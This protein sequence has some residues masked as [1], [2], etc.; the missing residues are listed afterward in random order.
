MTCL[1]RRTT[2]SETV[3]GGVSSSSSAAIAHRFRAKRMKLDRVTSCPRPSSQCVHSRDRPAG[4]GDCYPAMLFAKVPN[5]PSLLYVTVAAVCHGVI[6]AWSIKFPASAIRLWLIA[7]LT[8]IRI[9]IA[10]AGASSRLLSR[11]YFPAALTY[12]GFAGNNECDW[13]ICDPSC[14]YFRRV[15]QENSNARVK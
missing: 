6:S 4:G 2:Q 9:D 15:A 14:H 10:L 13:R 12:L 8:L 3:R 11:L 5:N 1:R 7:G